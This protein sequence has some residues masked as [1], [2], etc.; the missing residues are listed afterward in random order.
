MILG[1][2]KGV[3][4][5]GEEGDRLGEWVVFY[6]FELFNYFNSYKKCK[7]ITLRSNISQHLVRL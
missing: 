7:F 2:R 5:D 6:L 1:Q 4:G 3:D